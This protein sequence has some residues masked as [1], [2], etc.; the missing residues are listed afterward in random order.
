MRLAKPI[1]LPPIRKI[2]Q[3]RVRTN[4]QG[5]AKPAAVLLPLF[6]K[7]EEAYVLFTQR[8][9]QVEYH[10]GEISFPG[11]SRDTDDNSLEDTVLR[12]TEEEI[13]LPAAEIRLLGMLDDTKTLVSHFIITPFVGEIPYPYSFHINPLEIQELVE[14]PLRFFLRQECHWVSDISYQGEPAISHF[15]RWQESKVVWGATGRI[16]NNFCEIIL[17]QWPQEALGD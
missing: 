4:L 15:Y 6:W 2:L 12:E 10:K 1:F 8:T 3:E 13:G 11:G 5:T 7:Q 14:I 17:A 9:M 16:I